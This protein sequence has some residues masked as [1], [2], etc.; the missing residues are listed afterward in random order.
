MQSSNTAYFTA[1]R[2]GSSV[3]LLRGGILYSLKEVATLLRKG[4]YHMIQLKPFP[5]L[6]KRLSQI[7]QAYGT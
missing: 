4:G 3:Y 5:L 2:I 1:P 6:Q 7:E